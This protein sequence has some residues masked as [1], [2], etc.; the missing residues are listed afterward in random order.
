MLTFVTRILWSSQRENAARPQEMPLKV[1]ASPALTCHFPRV[2]FLD[3]HAEMCP[4]GP[5][6]ARQGCPLTTTFKHNPTF[7]CTTKTTLS[8][9]SRRVK[10]SGDADLQATAA[11]MQ[12]LQRP[13]YK[14]KKQKGEVAFVLQKRRTAQLQK[15]PQSS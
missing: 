13:R 9:E 3:V 6:G 7:A 12:P 11:A 14:T 1:H 8:Y 10:E 2:G 5:P 15:L 4:E